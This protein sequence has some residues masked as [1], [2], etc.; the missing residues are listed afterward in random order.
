MLHFIISNPWQRGKSFVISIRPFAQTDNEALLKVEKLCPQG[1]SK[2]A[3]GVAKKGDI[4]ARYKMYDNWKMSVAEDDGKIA[5]WIGCT[6]KEDRRRNNRYAYIAEVMVHP[7][8][9]RKGVVSKLVSEAESD[10]KDRGAD[11]VYCFLYESNHASKSL[12]QNLGY[13][14]KAL[15]WNCALMVHKKSRI[16]H[17]YSIENPG[18]DDLQEVAQLINNYNKSK[19]HFS[20]FTA[21]SFERICKQYSC[22]WF[23]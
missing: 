20:R 5:G 14:E 18:R 12:F 7:N 4:S 2:C 3:W 21:E 9:R 23:G 13:A 6:I 1:D 19:A 15:L 16:S 8:S 17:K 22:L 11:H 10:V